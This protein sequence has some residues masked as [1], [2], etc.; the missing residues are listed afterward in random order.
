[1]VVRSESLRAGL[2]AFVGPKS[3]FQKRLGFPL[4]TF[5]VQETQENARVRILSY[6]CNAL[7]TYITVFK[8]NWPETYERQNVTA[9]FFQQ[10]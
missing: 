7:V 3:R 5:L 4:K 1:M 6:G 8:G 2:V 10:D 9:Q